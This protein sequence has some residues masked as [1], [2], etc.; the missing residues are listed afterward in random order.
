ME[1]I[2]ALYFPLVFMLGASAALVPTMTA[3]IKERNKKRII[4][5]YVLNFVLSSGLFLGLAGI[6]NML[7]SAG[8]PPV[9]GLTIL[10]MIIY[11]IVN[12]IV[13]LL[14]I[15]KNNNKIEKK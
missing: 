13:L 9:I 1:W 6:F 15:K 4:I 11:M 2:P 10:A 8:T 5:T 7:F 3:K 14:N 12:T